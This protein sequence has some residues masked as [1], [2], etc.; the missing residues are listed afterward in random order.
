[1][2]KHLM[3][4]DDVFIFWLQHFT[5]ITAVP[6]YLQFCFS[7]FWLPMTDYS[8]EADDPPSDVSPEDQ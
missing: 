4:N 1:M 2:W 3:H 8:P 5:I 7:Q 6:P